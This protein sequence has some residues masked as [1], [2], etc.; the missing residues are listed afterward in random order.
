MKKELLNLLILVIILSFTACNPAEDRITYTYTITNCDHSIEVMEEPSN[1]SRVVRKLNYGDEIVYPSSTNEGWTKVTKKGESNPSGYIQTQY[2]KTDTTVITHSSVLREKYDQKYIPTLDEKYD[3]LAQNYIAKFPIKKASFWTLAIIVAIGIAIFYGIADIKCPLGAQIF[4]LLIYSPFATW[5]AF[6]TQQHGFAEID[7]FLPR[8][9]ILVAM[10]ALTLFMLFAITASFGK[11]LGHKLTFN[12]CIWSTLCI[13]FIYIGVSYFHRAC[14]FFLK[15]F[16]FVYA[17]IFIIFFIT[18]I[19]SRYERGER[20][21]LVYLR[22]II[23]LPIMF[24][25][26]TTIIN[27]LFMPMQILSSILITQ[28]SIL[29]LLATIA[30]GALSSLAYSGP[31]TTNSERTPSGSPELKQGSDG[32]WY[33]NGYANLNFN[34]GYYYDSNYHKYSKVGDNKYIK[35]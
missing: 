11:I 3:E 29:I 5:I 19:K 34:G 12:Y 16:I 27:C 30:V 15:F 32:Y 1:N 24:A 4:V 18:S 26:N 2:I 9:I 22:D 7:D 25:L 35:V 31:S 23:T 28:L 10:I 17:L 6:Y 21:W 8:L 14:D 33:V 13:Y 20:N